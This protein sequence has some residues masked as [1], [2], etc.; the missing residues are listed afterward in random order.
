MATG[1]FELMD[2]R[3]Y[4]GNLSEDDCAFYNDADDIIGKIDFYLHNDDIRV[5]KAEHGYRKVV[6]KMSMKSVLG[7]LINEVKKTKRRCFL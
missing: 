5:A 3:E 1:A 4:L 7:R 2:Y 6:D